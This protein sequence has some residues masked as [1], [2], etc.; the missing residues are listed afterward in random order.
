MS[1]LGMAILLTRTLYV[2]AAGEA[3]I[4]AVI[5]ILLTGAYTEK[6]IFDAFD[7]PSAKLPLMAKAGHEGRLILTS[8]FQHIRCYLGRL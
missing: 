5:V 6:F 7:S 4:G 2:A 1:I 3:R 8:K